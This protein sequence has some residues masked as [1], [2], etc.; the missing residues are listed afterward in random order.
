MGS[1]VVRAA[2]EVL[3]QQNSP[4]NGEDQPPMLAATSPQIVNVAGKSA[5]LAVVAI[6][7]APLSDVAEA[8]PP[9]A[10]GAA[11]SALSGKL[12]PSKPEVNTMPAHLGARKGLDRE[13]LLK[14]WSSLFKDNCTRGQ[15]A[16]LEQFERKGTII[17]LGFK[18]VDTVE[19][20]L[21][22]CL[23]GCFIGCFLGKAGIIGVAN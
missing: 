16:R 6:T 8:T 19:N 18:D 23:I 5:L 14:T 13:M 12:Q 21:G 7:A 3:S 17:L 1:G 9:A 22:C 2:G 10:E 15:S 4:T 20:S 11:T